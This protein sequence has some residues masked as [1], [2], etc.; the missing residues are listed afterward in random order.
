[1]T[2]NATGTTPLPISLPASSFG[3][4][5][6]V[7]HV[8]ARLWFDVDSVSQQA[9]QP[10][11]QQ[12][13]NFDAKAN[14]DCINGSTVAVN[15]HFV[16]YTVKNGL[17]RVLHRHS[18]LRTLLRAHLDARV[19]DIAFFQDGDILA[20]VAG[21]E[22]RS[23]LVIWRI[24]ERPPEVTAE[25][26]LEITS[27][28]SKITRVVWHPFNPNQFWMIHTNAHGCHIASLVETTKIRAKTPVSSSQSTTSGSSTAS[29][30]GNHVRC[31]FAQDYA[32][33]DDVV[34]IQSTNYMEDDV[35]DL[36]WNLRDAARYV[37]TSHSSGEIVLWDLKRLVPQPQF[38]HNL[39]TPGQIRVMRHPDQRPVTRC[40]FLPHDD[41]VDPRIQPPTNG[42]GGGGS[43]NGRDSFLTPCFA[44]G[45]DHNATITLWSAIPAEPS[46]S[47]PHP[48]QMLSLERPSP[49]YVLDVVCGIPA[50]D[51]SPLSSFLVMAD[52]HSGHILAFHLKSQWEVPKNSIS[53][54]NKQCLLAGSDYVVPF[55]TRYPIFSLNVQCT[56]TTDITEEELVDQAGLIFD[57]R[58]YAYQSKLVQCLTLTSY[59]CIPPPTATATWTKATPGVRV[60]RLVVDEIYP[61]TEGATAAPAA[62]TAATMKQPS[63]TT[64]PDDIQY[65]EDYDYYEG[66][67]DEDDGEDDDNNNNP[68]SSTGAGTTT[69]ASSDRNPFANW[70]GAI[71]AKAA[72]D[73]AATPPMPAIPKSLSPTAA[74]TSAVAAT[75]TTTTPA[76]TTYAVPVVTAPPASDLPA[77]DGEPLSFLSPSDFVAQGSSSSSAKKLPEPSPDKKQ[78]SNNTSEATKKTSNNNKPG[79]KSNKRNTQ[80]QN[81]PSNVTI[82][83]RDTTPRKSA[84]PSIVAGPPAQQQQQPMV[85]IASE[86]RQAV[87]EEIRNSVVPVVKNTIKESLNAAVISPLQSSIEQL[88]KQGVTV[89]H[90]NLSAALVGSVDQPLMTAFSESMKS[91][92]IPTLESVTGQILEN[93]S[94]NLANS[95][96][97]SNG[98]ASKDISAI[99]SQLTT[100]TELV[101]ELT[102]EVQALREM[103]SR[104]IPPA[105]MVQQPQPP[106]TPVNSVEMT[107]AEIR[108]LLGEKKFEAAFTKAVSAS[109][110][111]LAVFCCANADVTEVLAV[112]KIQLTQPIILCLVQQLGT[113]VATGRNTTLQ[114]ELEWLQ[115]LA[116]SLDAKDQQIQ[117]HVPRVLQQLVTSINA[118]M[119]NGDPNLRRPLQRLLSIIRGIGGS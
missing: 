52:R 85:D 101:A 91:V 23:T 117:Q 70:L 97:E 102:R 39:I 107:K 22:E 53:S 43:S 90:E 89:D 60:E 112:Q 76:S 55:K 118:R 64:T 2:D 10:Q 4:G 77:P 47:L 66:E 5:H 106:Q 1:M 33:M 81:D 68:A 105:H 16:V 78:N 80:Q 111:E 109:T 6:V 42:G 15:Q 12:I 88:S 74:R 82:L 36:A 44:T 67:N 63:T 24:F 7:T 72:D 48:L 108:R 8:P 113:V 26:L 62:S 19:T 49:S 54:N 69:D 79:K 34:T 35:T 92:F 45:S 84:P 116:L 21:N 59:M 61:T 73:T 57:T 119:A 20:T 9:Q 87:K 94:E 38:N 51:G 65:D 71:A 30:S 18:T 13:A 17:I 31:D 27:L 58:I 41:R 110:A 99:S 56:P 40:F 96:A 83:K 98:N 75:T 50:P 29:E 37:L 104:Q 95:T 115:D 32:L 103:Q 93:L 46:S 86:I 114:V 100:M 14:E 3:L 25:I 28:K 11:T